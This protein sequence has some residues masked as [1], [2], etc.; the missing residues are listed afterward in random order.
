LKHQ[1]VF[2]LQDFGDA[3]QHQRFVSRDPR[4]FDAVNPAIARLEVMRRN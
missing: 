3:I 4:H 2:W 1:P